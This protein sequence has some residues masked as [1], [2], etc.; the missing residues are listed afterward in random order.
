[1]KKWMKTG[2]EM[3]MYSPL[4]EESKNTETVVRKGFWNGNLMLLPALSVLSVP[5]KKLSYYDMNIHKNV[6]FINTQHGL[7]MKRIRKHDVENTNKSVFF[8]VRLSP[9]SSSNTSTVC[10]L[11]VFHMGQYLLLTHVKTGETRDFAIDDFEVM[12]SSNLNC[13]HGVLKGYWKQFD[14]EK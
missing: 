9:A 13:F 2:K 3:C 10:I 4:L 6:D 5:K 14:D 12:G 8:H 7:E 1:M 11:P